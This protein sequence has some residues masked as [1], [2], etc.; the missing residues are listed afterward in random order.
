M[1]RPAHLP[2]LDPRVA[3][4]PSVTLL[5]GRGVRPLVF[6]PIPAGEFVMGSRGWHRFDDWHANEEP[7]HRVVVPRWLGHGP[8]G[9]RDLEGIAFWMA[10]VP[11]TQGQFDLWK[12]DSGPMGYRA[13]F[14]LNK[15]ELDRDGEQSHQFSNPERFPNW[16]HHPA[17]HVAQREALAFGEWLAQVGGVAEELSSLAARSSLAT[18]LDLRLSLPCEALWEYAC[19]GRTDTDYWSGDGEA[20][21]A[22]VGWYASNS[23]GS[24]H[25]VAEKPANPWGLFDLHGNVWEWCLDLYEEA[26]HNRRIPGYPAVVPEADWR[27]LDRSAPRVV[28]G[29]SWILD[30]WWCR[31]AHRYW[32][33]TGYRVGYQGFRLCL[34]PVLGAQT[35]G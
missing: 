17:E 21:L 15:H 25:P 19:R 32:G 8:G 13:W 24:T 6:R 27:G 10:E 31:S 16:I 28:R 33:G 9:V 18:G 14:G 2:P 23:G 3:S 35:P 26:A 30:T 34:Y 22:E 5:E 4:M 20:A 12:A 7:A 29:G 1:Q 11:V